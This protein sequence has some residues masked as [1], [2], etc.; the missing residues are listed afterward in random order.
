MDGWMDGSEHTG[1]MHFHHTA[2]DR[3]SYGVARRLGQYEYQHLISGSVQPLRTVTDRFF[4]GVEYQVPV[5]V[6]W[7]LKT[8]SVVSRQKLDQWWSWK[9]SE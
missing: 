6:V 3:M 7:I 9:S 5:L 2:S 1:N 4:I 8:I